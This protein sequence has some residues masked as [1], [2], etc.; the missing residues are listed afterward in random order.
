M[1]FQGYNLD[2]GKCF[3]ACTDKAVSISGFCTGAVAKITDA[4]HPEMLSTD[5]M[6]YLQ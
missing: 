1:Y 4:A 2:K 6:I 3:G 5:C